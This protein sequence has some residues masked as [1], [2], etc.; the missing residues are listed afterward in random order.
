MLW[1][2][3]AKKWLGLFFF[4]LFL[5]IFLLIISKFKDIARFAALS[6]QGKDVLFFTLFQLPYILPLAIPISAAISSFFLF[7]NLNESHELNLMRTSGLSLYALFSPLLALSIL[8]SSA[9]FLI[10]SEIAPWFGKESR[11]IFYEKT[12][13]NP[14]ELFQRQSLIKTQDLYITLHVDEDGIGRDFLLIAPNQKTKRLSF[15]SIEKLKMKDRNL[16]G[17]KVSFLTLLPSKKEISFPSLFIENQEM[18]EMD[19]PLLS[20]ALKKHRPKADVNLLS[21]KMLFLASQEQAKKAKAASI[22]IL[23]RLYLS[24]SIVPLTLFCASLAITPKR[25]GYRKNFFFF[26]LSIV[27]FLFTYLFLK[28]LKKTPLLAKLITFSIPLTIFFFFLL[29]SYQ[30]QRGKR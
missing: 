11:K 26:F 7:R 23:R 2:Y 18:I 19:A 20:K 30:L 1:R 21:L 27:T 9:H 16:L 22:E 3:I 14:I 29:L 5:F 8:V 13:S 17:E 15:L 4:S 12:S 25:G 28:E 6:S 24:L 10:S